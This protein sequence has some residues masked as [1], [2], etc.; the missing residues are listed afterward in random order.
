MSYV[1]ALLDTATAEI[2]YLEKASNA[3]LDDKVKNAGDANYTKYARDLGRIKFFNTAKQGTPWCSVFV[4]W[5]FVKSFDVNTAKKA[6][7]QPVKSAAAGC[8]SAANY[9]K[10]NGAWETTPQPG[11][12]IFFFDKALKTLVHTGIVSR[13]TNTLVYTIEGNTNSTSGVV[14]NGGAVARKSYSRKY[15]RIAGYGRPD[16]KAIEKAYPPKEEEPMTGAEIIKALTPEQCVYIVQRA[17]SVMNQ[18][19]PPKWTETEPFKTE[20]SEA[21]RIGI[22]DGTKPEA[23]IPRYQAVLMAY[24]A[25]KNAVHDI[26]QALGGKTK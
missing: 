20:L 6:L 4:S 22:T 10:Q 3:Y 24:R 5:C 12:Q 15:N 18:L 19:P 11:D 23:L 1:T 21:E 9:F 13:V 7:Y 26:I 14:D 2:G 8:G 16:W 17:Q 25:Y